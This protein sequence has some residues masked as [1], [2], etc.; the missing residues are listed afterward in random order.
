MTVQTGNVS[1]T[2]HHIVYYINIKLNIISVVSII[3][4]CCSYE[5]SIYQGILKKVTVSTKN[6]KQHN[7]FNIDN[8]KCFL[9]IKSDY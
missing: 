9:S 7:Y 2:E 5:L 6:I 4:M 3:H 1:N 8:M